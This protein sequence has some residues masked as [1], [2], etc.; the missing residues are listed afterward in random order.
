VV[1]AAL[2]YWFI[3]SFFIRAYEVKTTS[4]DPSLTESDF[5]LVSPILYGIKA[6]FL[7][8]DFRGIQ[9]PERGDLVV[10]VP[11]YKNETSIFQKALE[12][13]LNFITLQKLNLNRDVQGKDIN[14]YSVK[15]I[16]GVPGDTVKVNNFEAFIKPEGQ[17][18]FINEFNLISVNYKIILENNAV[19]WS[20]T[21]PVSG[22]VDEII[23]KEN[24]YFLLGDNRPFSNDSRCWGPVLFESFI[25]KVIFR[26]W[27]F[28]KF[29]EF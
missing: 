16:I 7:E 22:N 2:A 29:G 26:Y 28:E 13:V 23:L 20:N 17:D 14:S 5:V 8:K 9:I 21:L 10:I 3:T 19:N 18:K 12:P 6:P 27:P 1:I 15:R 24:E 11:P 4:M 25:G